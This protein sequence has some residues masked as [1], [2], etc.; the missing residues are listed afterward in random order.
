MYIVE[1]RLLALQNSVEKARTD[2]KAKLTRKGVSFNTNDTLRK[3]ISLIP[4]KISRPSNLMSVSA[5]QTS[6][7]LDDGNVLVSYP[8]GV[9]SVTPGQACVFYAGD[10]CLGG[11]IIK[12][13][14]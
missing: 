11:G 12:A 3:L 6:V 2:L 1:E 9:K 13:A 7:P 14:L 4:R 8:E 10:K 5:N